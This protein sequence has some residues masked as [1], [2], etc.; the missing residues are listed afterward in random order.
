MNKIPLVSPEIGGSL[1]AQLRNK[2]EKDYV[3]EKLGKLDK[4]NPIVSF[5]IKNMARSSNDK[6][7]VAM[8]GIL[9]YELIQSQCE[10]NAMK[11][12]IPLE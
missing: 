1:Q 12:T 5:L 9:V 8:C 3:K 4:L 7:S 10:A 2:E 11:D 6:Q